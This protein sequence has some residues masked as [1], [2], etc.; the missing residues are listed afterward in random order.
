MKH[1]KS[2]PVT[3]LSYFSALI[4][5]LFVFVISFISYFSSY[6]SN[7]VRSSGLDD[8]SGF[9]ESVEE[10]VVCMPETGLGGTMDESG[11]AVGDSSKVQESVIDNRSEKSART[12]EEAVSIILQNAVVGFGEAVLSVVLFAVLIALAIMVHE[13][14]HAT[15][16][17]L[18]GYSIRHICIFGI[19]VS[20]GKKLRFRYDRSAAL[21]GY[22]V[23]CTEN[24]IRS[25]LMLLRLGPWFESIFLL[26][27]AVFAAL[28]PKSVTGIFLSGEIFAYFMVR[29]VMS[30]HSGDDD[31]ATAAQVYLDGR[32]DYNRLMDVYDEI[33]SGKTEII[34]E[35]VLS[36]KRGFL[37]RH[38]VV[39]SDDPHREKGSNK[40]L[41]HTLTIKEELSLYGKD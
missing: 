41:K 29:I 28:I 13:L 23:A 18:A 11:I 21:G 20:T 25:P 8:S 12:R 6:G 34:R 19:L 7:F 39:S 10:D 4:I 35:P 16:A 38:T 1:H 27:A 24:K 36:E 9:S 22:V 26:S 37:G 14:G 32:V 31:S 33:L 2:D 17:L 3:D 5:A 15:G 30:C 40:L